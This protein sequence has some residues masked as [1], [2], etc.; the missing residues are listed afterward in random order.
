LRPHAA[1]IYRQAC[2]YVYEVQTRLLGKGEDILVF[3]KSCKI[4]E[5]GAVDTIV[6]NLVDQGILALAE[7]Q[8]IT[9]QGNKFDVK[10]KIQTLT[11]ELIKRTKELNK[12]VLQNKT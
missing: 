9:I 1:E 8:T 3:T 10:G 6:Q 2:L 12:T 4:S 7:G 11:A 5:V